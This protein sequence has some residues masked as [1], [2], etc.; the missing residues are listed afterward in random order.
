MSIIITQ[1]N[2]IAWEKA[3]AKAKQVKP[4]VQVVGFGQFDVTGSKGETYHVTF[5]RNESG[6]FEV[7]C[8]CKGHTGGIPKPCYH[9]PQCGSIF[10]LQV[11]E[12]AAARSGLRT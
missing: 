6:E 7:S 2:K 3:I 1:E 4:R 10:K 11:R 12:R 8:S 9:C 5:T